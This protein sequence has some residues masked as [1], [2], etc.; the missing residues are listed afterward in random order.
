LPGLRDLVEYVVDNEH[1]INV[2]VSM[3]NGDFNRK[4]WPEACNALPLFTNIIMKKAV[5]MDCKSRNGYFNRLLESG[6]PTNLI[7]PG[8]KELY[9]VVCQKCWKPPKN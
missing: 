9:H 7:Q 1:P 3:L 8:G 2:Y 4:L 5:C 6:D